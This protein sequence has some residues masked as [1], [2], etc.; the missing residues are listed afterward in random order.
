MESVLLVGFCSIVLLSNFHFQRSGPFETVLSHLGATSH[1][2]QLSTS[3]VAGPDEMVST[4]PVSQTW[5]Q[6]EYKIS[7]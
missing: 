5:D 4:H 2:W 3:A 7:H 1:R 6:I